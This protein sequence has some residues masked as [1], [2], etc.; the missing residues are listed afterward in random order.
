MKDQVKSF[1]EALTQAQKKVSAEIKK[2]PHPWPGKT[3]SHPVKL[4]VR[5]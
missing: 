3:N 1:G 5:R 2:L 4:R